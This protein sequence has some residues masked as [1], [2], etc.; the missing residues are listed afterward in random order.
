MW[1][2]AIRQGALHQWLFINQVETISTF[3]QLIEPFLLSWMNVH[4]L[5][6][7]ILPHSRDSATPHHSSLYSHTNTLSIF[8]GDCSFL[9]SD[10]SALS[11]SLPR[12]PGKYF[13]T[14]KSGVD[15]SSTTKGVVSSAF[16]VLLWYKVSL[17][18]VTICQSS[19]SN[20][21]WNHKFWD[22]VYTKPTQGRNSI[23][24]CWMDEWMSE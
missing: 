9:T 17:N 6:T 8:Q 20:E 13:C 18:M 22:Y 2:D 3:S 5:S 24:I 12:Q 4:E 15:S 16:N 19:Y 21:L 7:I 10:Y 11:P 1:E 14:L 23:G